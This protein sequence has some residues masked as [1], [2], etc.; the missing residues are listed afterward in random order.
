MYD[1]QGS[2]LRIETTINQTRD[3][4]VFRQAQS[5]PHGRAKSEGKKSW[6][7]L[8]RSVV[9]LKRR[10]E[11]SRSA[12]DRYL[13]ALSATSGKVPLFQW[14]D[15]V[16]KPVQRE[17]R[18]VRSLNPWSPQDSALFQAVNRGEFK[19]NGFRNRDLRALLF[20]TKA[21]PQEQNRRSGVITRK[22]ALLRA[23]GL[24]KKLSGTHRYVLTQKGSTTITALLAARQAN[25]NHLTQ[26]AA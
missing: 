4:R 26:I 16:C 3:F 11:V 22:L 2:V 5:G 1:K 14:V 15:A 6:R 18:R 23:H 17:G 21:T 25:I 12:N 20:P 7:V 9:D 13:T 19:I 24:I 10:A 8:R